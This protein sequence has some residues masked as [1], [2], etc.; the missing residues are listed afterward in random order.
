MRKE[1]DD[2]D[3]DDDDDDRRGPFPPPLCPALSFS[4]SASS[5]GHAGEPTRLPRRGPS[6]PSGRSLATVHGRFPQWLLWYM[7]LLPA[8]VVS[9]CSSHFTSSSGKMRSRYLRRGSHTVYR[10]VFEHTSCS[11]KILGYA[12]LVIVDST[13]PG[14]QTETE[15][16]AFILLAEK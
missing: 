9:S 14:K 4:F 10:D 5:S 1:E 13:P 11:G 12:F 8:S 3:D 2:D 6:S 7:L 15:T 16:Y